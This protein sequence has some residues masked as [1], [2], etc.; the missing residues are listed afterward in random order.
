[1][2]IITNKTKPNNKMEEPIAE[3]N[4]SSD[5]MDEDLVDTIDIDNDCE[6]PDTPNNNNEQ[7]LIPNNP[8]TD[9][10]EFF[11]LELP[12][13]FKLTLGSC[14]IS[15]L[16]LRNIGLET[17]HHILSLNGKGKIPSYIK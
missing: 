2:I 13:G 14:F 1:M 9:S 11:Q 4:I 5:E 8:L 15:A 10:K 6:E 7:S 16:A 17:Y 12:D 3:L